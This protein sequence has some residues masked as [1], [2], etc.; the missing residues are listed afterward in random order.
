M[1]GNKTEAQEWEML[2]SIRCLGLFPNSK[3]LTGRTKELALEYEDLSRQIDQIHLKID[4]LDKEV[5]L[6][7]R[8]F[9]YYSE[10]D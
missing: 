9:E 6:N 7:T 3:K 2:R 1:P 5:V 10:K 8:E 4:E